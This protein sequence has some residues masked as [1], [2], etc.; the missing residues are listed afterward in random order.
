MHERLRA[1]FLNEKLVDVLLIKSASKSLEPLRKG[2][3]FMSTVHMVIARLGVTR[4]LEAI[5]D[6]DWSFNHLWSKNAARGS[7]KLIP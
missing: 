7:A 5:A 2:G 6:A 3:I 4:A 1:W